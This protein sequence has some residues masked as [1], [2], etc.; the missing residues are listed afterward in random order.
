VLSAT[1]DVDTARLTW[2]VLGQAS[3][4]TAALLGSGTG[5]SASFSYTPD[6]GWSGSDSFVVQTTDSAG[7]TG[8]FTVPVAVQAVN[9]APRIAQGGVTGLTVGEDGTATRQLSATDADG[10]ALRW[11][12]AA[13]PAHGAASV[14][15][16]ADGAATVSYT[17]APGFHGSD[18]FVVRV[19][20]G[21]GGS[22]A[23]VVDVSVRSDGD[24][25][26]VD[27][28]VEAGA[29]NG[30][31]ANG[32]GVPDADQA[33]VASFRDQRTGRYVAVA[34]GGGC[35]LSDVGGASRSTGAGD[36]GFR[37]P[38]G[39]VD[40]TARCAAGATVTATAYFY[41]PPDGDLVVRK[42]DPRTGSYTSVDGA[43]LTRM[44]IGGRSVVRARYVVA[45][46]GPLDADGAVNGRIVDPVGLARPV[47]S[48]APVATGPA[49]NGS[50]PELASTGPADTV[51]LTTAAAVAI[52]AGL[53]L[54]FAGRRRPEDLDRS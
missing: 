38:V 35:T 39:L 12:L 48:P 37:Y 53:F 23:I 47:A 33:N 24:D 28:A 36:T 15:T 54:L 3:H 19:L 9:H 42:F 20:D 16:G 18:R 40:F 49:P 22:D 41:G 32:D 8:E 44:T 43:R 27:G 51:P 26:G 50:V 30:G 1:D 29:P 25:D 34:V 11:E 14:R 6:P 4:G 31:D 2:S 17:P 10:D 46:G 7:A 52:S 21:Q 45:D 5:A 13:S